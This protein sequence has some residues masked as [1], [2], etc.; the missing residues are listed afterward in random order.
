M[1]K[2]KN[3]DTVICIDGQDFDDPRD[4]KNQKMVRFDLI[5][6]SAIE[7]IREEEDPIELDE[8]YSTQ[9][10]E[11]ATWFD[12]H[13]LSGSGG[14][15]EDNIRIIT[16]ILN[17]GLENYA[18][19]SEDMKRDW[20]DVMMSRMFGSHETTKHIVAPDEF[21]I[22]KRFRMFKSC[23]EDLVEIFQSIHEYMDCTW[24]EFAPSLD[25][26]YEIRE[27]LRSGDWNKVMDL[28]SDG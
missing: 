3:R 10:L 20:V 19:D 27:A 22:I 25:P 2:N 16:E 7:D 12:D 21:E 1:N 26:R 13:V 24:E 4:R 9:F 14:S 8:E 18:S 6:A 23:E 17:N 28:I 11:F 15:Y 5:M